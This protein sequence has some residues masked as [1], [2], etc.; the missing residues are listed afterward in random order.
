MNMGQAVDLTKAFLIEH[1][2]LIIL[3]Q[4][5]PTVK[6]AFAKSVNSGIRV[7]N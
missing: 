2:K 1:G 5:I 4:A 7:G 6:A 3:D